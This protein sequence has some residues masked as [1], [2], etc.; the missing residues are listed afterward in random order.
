M[1]H[2]NLNLAAAYLKINEYVATLIPLISILK[3]LL[4]GFKPNAPVIPLYRNIEVSKDIGGERKPVK[5]RD[6]LRTH[7]KVNNQLTRPCHSE[8][9]QPSDLRAALKLQPSNVEA[10]AELAN[11]APT[12]R[13]TKTRTS[14]SSSM[15]TPTSSATGS[16]PHRTEVSD[17][18]RPD[19]PANEDEASLPFA[20]TYRDD[21]RLKI[22]SLP[23]TIDVPVDL[24]P[25]FIGSHEKVRRAAPPPPTSVPTRIETF[26]Y[27]NWER[28]VIQKIT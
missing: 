13:H 12:K 10:A 6:G 15:S 11:I 1:P 27:P 28:Y 22:S 8:L 26:S 20:K 9:T 24:P 7:S 2:Y 3:S 17:P 21:F 16:S 25:P 18:C 23:L 14:P 19:V 5:V 4:V